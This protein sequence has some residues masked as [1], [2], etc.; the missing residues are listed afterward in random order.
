MR[1]YY[2]DELPGDQRLMHD[3]GEAVSEQTL[4]GLGV[5]YHSIPIDAEGM[6]KQSIDKF[7]LARG[8]KNR[9]QISVTPNGLGESYEAK[10]K[11]HL[12]DDEEIRFI[13]DGSGFFDI[14]DKRWIR[15]HLV[16]GDLI[17]LPLGIY[18]RFTVDEGNDITAMR[19]FQDEP[20]W[21]PYSRADNGTD[22]RESRHEYV[23][24]VAVAA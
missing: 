15:I 9:D 16:Q 23:K 14:R 20:K 4:A 5:I 6:W 13:L 10:I 22:S 17:V 21:C 3:S 2:Y 18:H 11:M 8:Y 1:A 7:A 12:H 24:S 19:L